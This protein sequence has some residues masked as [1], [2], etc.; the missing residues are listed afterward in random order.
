MWVVPSFSSC[1][2]VGKESQLLLKPT[3]VELGLQVGVEFAKIDKS[4]LI[5]IIVWGFNPFDSSMKLH[6]RA[7]RYFFRLAKKCTNASNPVR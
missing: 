6:L 5:N 4:F 1:S 2:S 3:E 7:A